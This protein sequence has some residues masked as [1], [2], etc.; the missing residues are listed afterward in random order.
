MSISTRSAAARAAGSVYP[1]LDWA[2]RFLRGRTFLTNVGD[3]PARAYWRS[4]TRMER[5]EAALLLHPDLAARLVEHD[6]FTA[7]EAFYR[8]PQV[9]DTL[10]R[11]QYADFH[12]Y[13]PDQILAKVDRASMGV[14]LEVRVPLLDHR[15]VGRFANLPAGE[16]V[17]GGRG[18]HALREA[19]RGRVS[20]ALLDGE[21]RGFDTPLRAWVRGPLR[22]AVEEA[23]ASLPADWFRRER[24]NAALQAHL[25]GRRDHG[26]L[27][28]S[29][30]VLEHWRRRHGVR[31]LAP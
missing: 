30:L 17:R 31:A 1:R 7:F 10:Y 12:T 24:L 4:V 20:Q 22:A 25:S 6:P 18:K 23:V 11:A 9:D 27:L 5:A 26:R 19:L 16:K 28:W 15:L 2:P 13:L 8:R 3:D 21:K 14:S 29:L